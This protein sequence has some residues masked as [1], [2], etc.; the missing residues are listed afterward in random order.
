MK[1]YR[2]MADLS[3]PGER[4]GVVRLGSFLAVAA[5]PTLRLALLKRRGFWARSLDRR[6]RDAADLIGLIVFVVIWC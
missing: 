4:K 1:Y 3:L 5:R 6:K 2:E